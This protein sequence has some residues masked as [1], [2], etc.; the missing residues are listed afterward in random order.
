MIQA[1]TPDRRSNKWNII[2]T[3]PKSGENGRFSAEIAEF[4]GTGFGNS[5]PEAL[6]ELLIRL[7][8][9]P[10]FPITIEFREDHSSKPDTT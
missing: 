6:G 2:L 7:C 9:Q 8:A 3:G 1:T 5:A 4:E 10:K